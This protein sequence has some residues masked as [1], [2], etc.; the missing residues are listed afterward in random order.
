MA[1]SILPCFCSAMAA[2]RQRSAEAMPSGA[3]A[4]LSAIHFGIGVTRLLKGRARSKVPGPEPTR[5]GGLRFPNRLVDEPLEDSVVF[6]NR[7]G[8]FK[9]HVARFAD[10]PA[11]LRSPLGVCGE[12]DGPLAVP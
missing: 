8:R 7:I 11:H 6:G 9:Q 3:P 1:W 2:C 12:A 4:P 5:S 10:S